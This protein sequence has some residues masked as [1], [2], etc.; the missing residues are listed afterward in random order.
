[1]RWIWLVALLCGLAAAD[2]GIVELTDDNFDGYM[3]NSSVLMVKFFAPWCG[4]C[5]AFAPEYEKAAKMI[6]EQGK[7]YVLANL[8]ATVHKKAA[9]AHKIQGFP[10][11]KLFLNGHPIDYDGERKAEAVITFIDKKTSPAS[12]EL[13][14]AEAVQQK[15]DAKGLRCM[16]LTEDV[17]AL[18]SYMEVAKEVDDYTFFHVAPKVAQA[19][20][21]DAVAGDVILLKD[22]DEKMAIFKGELN[23][24]KLKEFLQEHM[25]PTVTEITQKVIELIFRPNAR[26][27]L[28]LF[29]SAAAANA[30]TVDA[31]FQKVATALK[32]KDYLFVLSDIN[33][34]W[35]KRVADYFGI[36]EGDLPLVEGVEMKQDIERRRHSGA[37]TEAELKTFFEN[38]KKGDVPR[39]L[40]SEPEPTQSEGPVHKLVG[41]AFKRDVLDNDL[42][43]I[44]KFYAPW[45]GHCKKL[46]PIYKS[47]A[48][49]QVANKLLKF[50]EVDATKN[51]IEGHPIQG[52]PVI[53]LFPGKNKSAVA[54]YEGDRSEADIAKFLKEKCSHPVDFPDL[55]PKDEKEKGK[56]DL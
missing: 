17:K 15:K 54:T 32:S 20:F 14:D 16:F 48:E 56:D 43:V 18:A 8:D 13:K 52:F 33:D 45:C 37:V 5:K 47:L 31:E 3:K 29:R 35:G 40:K 19:V 25:L 55:K 38:W 10:T 51:D 4:H 28:F 30:K 34:G 53:K 21:K 49:A 12:Q 23:K 39:Y 1:M 6:K 7:P 44:V 9:E 36:V 46:E 50:F 26:K 27:G 42:D 11:V 41:K 2:E 24:E 22:F